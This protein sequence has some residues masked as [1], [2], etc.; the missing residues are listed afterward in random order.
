V[1]KSVNDE[2]SLKKDDIFDQYL[3]EPDWS[4][5]RVLA[6][7]AVLMRE[8][9]HPDGRCRMM[10]R[11]TW[12][13]LLPRKITARCVSTSGEK[14]DADTSVNH[15]SGSY[16]AGRERAERAASYSAVQ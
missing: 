14:G 9:W 4:G 11:D 13:W 2:V 1:R 10:W 7:S 15:D 8:I 5:L 12:I 3:E 16:D 6:E